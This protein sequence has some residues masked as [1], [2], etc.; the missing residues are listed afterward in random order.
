MSFC[1]IK[2]KIQDDTIHSYGIEFVPLPGVENANGAERITLEKE[3][4]R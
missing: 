1:E 4:A 2:K 3:D